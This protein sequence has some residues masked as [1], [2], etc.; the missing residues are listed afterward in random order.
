MALAPRSLL[1]YHT[2][3]LLAGALYCLL[4][5][6]PVALHAS[7]LMPAAEVQPEPITL[8]ATAP[9][10]WDELDVEAD[11]DA[12]EVEQPHRAAGAQA[13]HPPLQGGYRLSSP[14]GPRTHPIRG[15]Q[16][17]HAGADLA[18]PRGTPVHA[19]S[20]GIV[21]ALR[22]TPGGYGRLV[23]VSHA[24]GYSSWYAHLQHFADGLRVGQHVQRGTLLGAVGSSGAATGPHLHLEIRHHAVPQ[25]PMALLT[26]PSP[27]PPFAAPARTVPGAVTPWRHQASPP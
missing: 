13:F 4:G 16:H 11:I 14:F 12:R 26:P 2:W 23:T 20:D 25:E 6:T 3:P 10:Q 24:G 22:S 8:L 17:L 18:A 15:R 7:A 9:L 5:M 27:A 19:V 21:T 1:H